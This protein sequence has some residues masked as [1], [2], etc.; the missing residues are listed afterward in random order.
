MK[1]IKSQEKSTKVMKPKKT[2]LETVKTDEFKTEP[3]I[4]KTR[5]K[6]IKEG[7]KEGITVIEEV[8]ESKV[9]TSMIENLEVKKENNI[10]RFFKNLINKFYNLVKR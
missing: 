8:T 10:I 4:K 9:E 6:K 3:K 7:F 5:V 1:E 2:K